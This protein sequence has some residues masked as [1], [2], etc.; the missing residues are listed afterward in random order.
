MELRTFDLDTPDGPMPCYEAVP[1]GVPGNRRGALIVV[2]EAFG[3]NAHI[4]DVT[5]RFADLGYHAIAPGLFHRTGSPALG[6]DD[7]SMVMEHMAALDD[8]GIL[9]DLGAVVD[10][11][12]TI[13]WPAEQIGIVGFCMGGRATFLVA[14]R[15]ALGAAVGFYPSAVV[16]GRNERMGSLLG[17]VPTLRTPWL[18]LFGD[19]DK[20]IPIA[21]VERLRTELAEHAPVDTSVVRY[22]N[23]EHGFHCDVRSSYAAVAA[24]A[25]WQ[26]TIAWFDDH[27]DPGTA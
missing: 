20:G 15:M 26:R 4:E 1:D 9:S 11:L 5:R 8:D 14:G 2:Q 6:Y 12:S 10:H 19:E 22:P 25:A 27:I 21:D 7:F 16:T 13:G 23:A 17:T 24:A 18:G 3:V